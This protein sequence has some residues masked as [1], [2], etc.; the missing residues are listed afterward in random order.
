MS[1]QELLGAIIMVQANI[2]HVQQ[3]SMSRF[4]GLRQY[5]DLV[6]QWSMSKIT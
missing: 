4:Y 5:N 2:D 1:S 6:Q 3:W